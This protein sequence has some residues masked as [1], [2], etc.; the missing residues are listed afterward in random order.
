MIFN[1]KTDEQ[2]Y[3][4]FLSSFGKKVLYFPFDKAIED[5]PEANYFNEKINDNTYWCSD[6]HAFIKQYLI[7]IYSE[8][9]IK[10]LITPNVKFDFIIEI[11]NE[12][13][14]L[15]DKTIYTLDKRISSYFDQTTTLKSEKVKLEIILKSIGLLDYSLEDVFYKLKDY[16]GLDYKYYVPIVWA[17]ARS[18]EVKFDEELFY[19]IAYSKNYLE[20]SKIYNVK[21]EFDLKRDA[22]GRYFQ[23][24]YNDSSTGRIFPRAA[25]L[26]TLSTERRDLL[27]AEPNC[28][29]IEYDMAYFEFKIIMNLLNM[30]STVDPHLDILK[31][32]GV[33]LDRKIGKRINY[34]YLYGMSAEKVC[35]VILEEFNVQ[36]DIVR[37]K[38]YPFFKRRLNVDAYDGIIFTYFRRPVKITKAHAAF[39]NYVQGT[40]ADIFF[41][42]FR[43]IQAILPGEGLD[44][45]ILQNHDSILI[46]LQESTINSTNIAQEIL[47]ILKA[48]IK[49][50]T[51]DVD[52]KYG[53]KWSELS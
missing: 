24:E 7:D 19:D 23:C 40:A 38:E 16:F 25:S 12:F 22:K 47:D 46:Q 44:K 36:L 1:L 6:V 48:P 21:S 5:F 17:I 14:C 41:R 42:K 45:I 49:L 31:H 27:E 4:P 9:S 26:Q 34:S 35:E 51:F 11:D 29:L 33:D 28:Y 52:M 15:K 32:L 8:Y 43:Q 18:Q 3:N 13:I 53:R 30:D 37:L 10:P 2:I 50:F 39:Q 20:T